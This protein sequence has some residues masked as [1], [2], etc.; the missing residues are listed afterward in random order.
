MRIV[1]ECKL[2]L[3]VIFLLHFQ[4]C[5]AVRNSK[6][7]IHVVLPS[8]SLPPLLAPPTCHELFESD[9]SSLG[10]IIRGVWMFVCEILSLSLLIFLVRQNQ[11]I[12]WEQIADNTLYTHHQDYQDVSREKSKMKK[13]NLHRI[14]QKKRKVEVETREKIDDAQLGRYLHT[15]FSLLLFRSVPLNTFV[16][17]C[18]N[19]S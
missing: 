5:W 17:D 1:L 6:N 13:K 3:F 9:V 18:L 7:I 10:I 4:S 2:W 11:H 14:T 8:R 16:D 15:I 19:C 12:F